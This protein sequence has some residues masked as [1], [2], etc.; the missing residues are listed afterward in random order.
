MH[1]CKYLIKS[2]LKGV[3]DIIRRENG[4][5]MNVVIVVILVLL[6]LLFGWLAFRAWRSRRGWL[7]WIGGI[8]SSLLTLVFLLVTAVI[9]LGF[10][11]MN[12][13]P[14]KYSDAEVKLAMTPE[15]IA[16]GERYANGCTGC[17]A[18]TGQ[19]PLDGGSE[20]LLAG[21][22]LG[23]VYAPN[24][25]PG[26]PLKDWTDTEIIRAIREGVRKNGQPLMVMP[27]EAFQH[28]S[29]DDVQAVVAYLRSQP[30]V[31]HQVP[32]RNLS[33]MAAI[34]VGAGMLP[35]SAQPPITAPVVAPQTG[36]VA[37]GE[38]LSRGFG[39]RD[40]HGPDLAGQ[41]SNYQ[42][43]HGPNL[44]ALVPNW[45][46]EN[47]LTLF[48]EG[49]DPQGNPVPADQ[50]P[51]KEY[52]KVFTDEQLIDLYNYIHALPLTQSPK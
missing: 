47:F 30:A 35:T 10:Y 17:H 23:S 51:W 2:T 26:G 16:L 32:D 4:F 45:T 33:V 7:K 20:N 48:H 38:Y 40:C 5:L 50:M 6:V 43:P 41:P 24:L 3:L 36:T 46:Q 13:A 27:S 12:A 1:V 25:T 31:E 37:Y 29:D 28:L 52:Q 8:L 14:Y 21:S 42:G 11:K 22:P 44:T 49:L 9:L 19:L 18:T 34:F 39:C 15:Q